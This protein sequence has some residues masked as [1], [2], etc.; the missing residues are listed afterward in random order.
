MIE[1]MFIF[2]CLRKHLEILGDADVP[3]TSVTSFFPS[4]PSSKG[5]MKLQAQQ[6]CS[7]QTWEQ[8]GNS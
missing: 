1:L 8:E 3:S 7:Y 6:L 2:L 5:P 4:S